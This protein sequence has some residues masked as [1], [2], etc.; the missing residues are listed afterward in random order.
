MLL[1][2]QNQQA[3]QGFNQGDIFTFKVDTD[4]SNA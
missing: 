3:D 4:A 1:E 2:M